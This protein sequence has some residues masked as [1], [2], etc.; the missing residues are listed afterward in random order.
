MGSFT[1]TAFGPAFDIVA[2]TV[3]N[4]KAK[5]MRGMLPPPYNQDF[6]ST[7][8]KVLTVIGQSDNLIGGLFDAADFLPDAG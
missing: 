8:S 4:Y 3:D 2:V 1:G 5:V 6:T 7:V